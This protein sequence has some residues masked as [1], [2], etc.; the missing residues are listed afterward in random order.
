MKNNYQF[1]IIILITSTFLIYGYESANNRR[2]FQF[3]IFRIIHLWYGSINDWGYTY[4]SEVA[5]INALLDLNDDQDINELFPNLRVLSSYIENLTNNSDIRGA[6]ESEIKNH[7]TKLFISTTLAHSIVFCDLF[8]KY[9]NVGFV[10]MMECESEGDNYAYIKPAHIEGRYLSGLTCGYHSLDNNYTKVGFVIPR[11]SIHFGINQA[12]AF[13]YGARKA[14]PNI[15]MYIIEINDYYDPILGN[16]AAKILADEG[17]KCATAIEDTNSVQ[18]YFAANNLWSTGYFFEL[19]YSLG[20]SV[21]YSM[22]YPEDKAFYRFSKEYIL[23]NKFL[24]DG[25]QNITDYP[26]KSGYSNE[27]SIES[28]EKVSIS[29]NLIVEGKLEPFC[30]DDIKEPIYHGLKTHLVGNLTCLDKEEYSKMTR[31]SESI[32]V[33]K[34][35]HLEDVIE[36]SYFSIY[37]VVG[38]VFLG[39]LIIGFIINSLFLW[40]VIRNRNLIIYKAASPVFCIIFL[41]ALYLG[42]IG[43]SF[44]LL[45]PSKLNCTSKIWLINLSHSIVYSCLIFKNWRIMKLFNIKSSLEVYKIS[46]RDLLLKMVLPYVTGMVIALT[47]WTSLDTYQR[48]EFTSND[49]NYLN[50]NQIEITCQ[51]KTFYGIY[52][53][54][55][56]LS[57][58]LLFGCIVAYKT[59]GIKMK[60]YREAESTAWIVYH[61]L[62]LIVVSLFLRVIL[63]EKVTV[64]ISDAILS[65]AI[66]LLCVTNS[67]ILLI[68]KVYRIHIKGEKEEE[69]IVNEEIEIKDV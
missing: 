37:T 5:R 14:N 27:L 63:I 23:N 33:L 1:S 46:N 28:Q 65:Y 21:L 26:I 66:W 32:K 30:G 7:G 19:R 24:K 9:M 67:L 16:E 43:L 61:N 47:L 60:H 4:K 35:L 25:A 36:Y 56:Y 6:I 39:L 18:K 13:F 57:L 12:N 31:Y 53:C 41:S 51:S 59:K 55:I 3:D 17:V 69:S 68:P 62:L 10:G 11:N 8:K 49:K 40:D 22:V 50:L 42:L 45:E 2:E 48:H 34:S 15:E 38:K 54:I 29:H 20:E 64:I 44:W 58:L 52:T